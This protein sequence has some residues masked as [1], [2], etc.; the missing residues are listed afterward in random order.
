MILVSETSHPELLWALRGGGG[1]FGVA[2][3]LTYRLRP[4]SEVLGGL[5]LYRGARAAEA[6]AAYANW[7]GDLPDE[8]TTLGGFCPRRQSRSCPRTCSCSRHLP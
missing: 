8:L 5:L 6:A 1:N 2:T 4:L 7:V 3:S